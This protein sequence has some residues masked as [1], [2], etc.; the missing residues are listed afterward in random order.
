MSVIG[1]YAAHL[2]LFSRNA[3]LYLGGTF[4]YG[5]GLGAFWV[6][7]N[8]YLRALGISDTLIGRLLAFQSLGTVL[9]A[10]PAGVIATRVRLKWMLIAATLITVVAFSLLVTLRPYPLLLAAAACAGAGFV[11]HQ[12]LAAPF[13]MRNS[14]PKERI[15]LFG[16]NWSVEILASVVGVA[17][18]GW[19]AHHLAGV[20]GSEAEALRRTLLG[21]TALMALALAPYLLIRSPR[22]RSDESASFRLWRYRRPGLL[23]KLSLPALLVG[24]GAGL[25][26]PFLNLYFR[27]RFALDA[28]AIGTI[29]SVSQGLMALGFAVGPYMARRLGMVRA[30]A[31]TELLSI[32]FFLTMAFSH[33]LGLAVVAFWARGA[34]MNMNQPISRNFA[35]EVV[36][37]DQQPIA[38]AVIMLSWSLSWMVS[39]QVG[40]WL[41]DHHGFAPPMLVAVLLYLSSSMLYLFFFHDYERRVLALRPAAAGSDPPRQP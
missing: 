40:G 5:F 26:I 11:I 21:A 2:R 1:E 20:L 29:F 32:P 7:L 16:V 39:T 33:N 27:D 14:T 34:L 3:R 28:G 24:C 30:V 41:I 8:L 12:V 18:G 35:M 10:I 23:A 15:Y 9:V 19:F 36:D 38:N 31:T 25:V 17:G 37:E 22:P 4:F 13:F 6:L